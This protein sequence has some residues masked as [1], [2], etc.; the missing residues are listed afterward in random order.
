MKQPNLLA[1]WC[2]LGLA[3]CELCQ[4]ENL[5]LETKQNK[6]KLGFQIGNIKLSYSKGSFTRLPGDRFAAKFSQKVNRCVLVLRIEK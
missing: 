1:K 4:K 5:H 2:Q 6:T 3:K